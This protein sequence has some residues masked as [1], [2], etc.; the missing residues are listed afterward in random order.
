[1]LCLCWCP[2]A[3]PPIPPQESPAWPECVSADLQSKCAL[4]DQSDTSHEERATCFS[5]LWELGSIVPWPLCHWLKLVSISQSKNI[6]FQFIFDSFGCLLSAV[7]LWRLFS[8]LMRPTDYIYFVE[9]RSN[10][11]SSSL[12]LI[13][14]LLA[15]TS[16]CCCERNQNISFMWSGTVVQCQN[17][18]K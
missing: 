10:V 3:P 4:S 15:L 5:S 9:S 18:Q 13:S 16:L 1:M 17:K 12:Q 6:S 7:D 11:I 2:G 14:Q 8:R